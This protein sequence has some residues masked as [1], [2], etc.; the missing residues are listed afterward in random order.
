MKKF[1]FDI[2]VR[3]ICVLAV[4]ALIF[5]YFDTRSRKSADNRQS[6][7]DSLL[8]M[9]DDLHELSVYAEESMDYGYEDMQTSLYHLQEE[10][11]KLSEKADDLSKLF[12][13]PENEDNR[14]SWWY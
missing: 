12:E 5:L 3:I 4:A 13:E 6:I 10:C 11:Q 9:S 1:N 8:F 7:Q 14:R 2:I